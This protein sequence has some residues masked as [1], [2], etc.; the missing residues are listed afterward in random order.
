MVCGGLTEYED[1]VY[2]SNDEFIR[3]CPENIIRHRLEGTRGGFKSKR[4]FQKLERSMY[5]SNASLCNIGVFHQNLGKSVVLG[6]ARRGRGT[7]L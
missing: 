3:M 1:I 4:C 6:L 2:I 5:R 7:R